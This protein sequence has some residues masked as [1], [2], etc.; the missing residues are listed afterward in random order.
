MENGIGPVTEIVALPASIDQAMAEKGKAVFEAKCSACHKLEE[1][2]VGPALGAVTKRRTAAYIMNMIL[3]PAEMIQ[4]HPVAKQLLAEHLTP[5]PN[6]GLTQQ[7]AREV[8]E[9]LRA[10]AH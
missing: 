5:M 1:K 2:Y 4:R 9:Y 10:E 7:E 6:Q 3:N 8:V